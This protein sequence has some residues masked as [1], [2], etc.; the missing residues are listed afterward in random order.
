MNGSRILVLGVAYKKDVDDIRESPALKI[1][2]LLRE[3]GAALAY[4]DPHVPRLPPTRRYDFSHLS[5]VPLDGQMNQY[6][7]VVLVTDHSAYNMAEIV[8][9]SR[10]VVDTRNATRG[11]QCSS[12]K[13]VRC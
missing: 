1:M 5:S 3:R 7:C 10:L 8:S 13:V 4:N 11:V 6:D 9:H 12:T 2:D